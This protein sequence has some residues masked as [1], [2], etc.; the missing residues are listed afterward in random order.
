MTTNPT[1]IYILKLRADKYYIGRTSN[2]NVRI[3]KHY[4]EYGS[5]W[6]YKYKPVETLEVIPDCDNFDED[7]ITKQYMSKFGIDNV[8]GGSYC[9]I[10]LSSEQVDFINKEINNV[11]NVCY[12]CGEDGHFITQC[13][14]NTKYKLKKSHQNI[15]NIDDVNFIEEKT[16]D[17]DYVG[18]VDIAD[19][20]QYN[21]PEPEPEPDT[22]DNGDDDDGDDECDKEILIK[23]LKSKK[24]K[25]SEKSKNKKNKN[26]S[27]KSKNKK[28]SKKSKK[29]IDVIIE[30][31][32]V[33]CEQKSNYNI[34]YDNID[35]DNFDY[36]DFIDMIDEQKSIIGV[37]NNN[38]VVK[39]LKNMNN[40]LNKTQ[41][42]KKFIE[43]NIILLTSYYTYN[44]L[45]SL[46]Q[47]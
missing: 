38:S 7:K 35:Y 18:I 9:Q 8:R 43:F 21:E 10:V 2:P 15:I 5:A 29:S 33:N 20:H 6:T 37:I 11:K 46:P 12:K 30:D 36:E 26:K 40:K 16:Y 17:H 23:S 22:R 3:S 14:L 27:S 25:K 19:I 13:P 24:K 32:N 4:N 42:Y 44:I 41:F 39:Y 28:K 47:S 45:S 31:Y 1:Y 34:D